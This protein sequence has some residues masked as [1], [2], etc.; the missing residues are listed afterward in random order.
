MS[1]STK[2]N[3][4]VRLT[5]SAGPWPGDRDLRFCYCASMVRGL[6]RVFHTYAS[7]APTFQPCNCTANWGLHG[8]SP[9]LLPI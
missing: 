9:V 5:N 2:K 4:A 1:V 6:W 7:G 3:G 8:Y